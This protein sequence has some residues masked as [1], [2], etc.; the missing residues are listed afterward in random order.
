M[1]IPQHKY[2]LLAT[3]CL[4]LSA[5][6]CGGKLSAANILLIA[7]PPPPVPIIERMW[8]EWLAQTNAQPGRSRFDTADRERPIYY[9]NSLY[10]G[11][12]GFTAI[13]YNGSTN[14]YGV[15]VTA[16]TRRH[17][18]WR[19]HD[20]GQYGWNMTYTNRLAQFVTAGNTLLKLRVAAA[21]V[22]GGQ[23][24]S[25]Q[26][27]NNGV[28]ISTNWFGDYSVGI[29]AEDLPADVEPM[30]MVSYGQ[31]NAVAATA[32]PPWG[33]THWPPGIGTEQSNYV[34]PFNEPNLYK[35]G[36]SGSPNMWILDGTLWMTGGRT[37][38]GWTTNMQADLD[39]LA[40]WAGLDPAD[41]QPTLFHL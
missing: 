4:M 41:Y 8:A 20:S 28:A 15:P 5:A 14:S 23:Y 19:G 11:L 32:G 27:T 3:V 18:Y 12:K 29:L 26:F 13:G 31:Q 17:I 33:T 21:I 30:A 6:L 37:T 25:P 36:D 9:T 10:Y 40:T 7:P 1:K 16:L 34:G 24:G 39:A 2:L 38:S 35:S 22:R